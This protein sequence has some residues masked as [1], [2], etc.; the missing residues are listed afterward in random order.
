MIRSIFAIA[1]LV[2]AG[3]AAVQSFPTHVQTQSAAIKQSGGPFSA[4]YAGNYSGSD[5]SAHMNG[6]FQFSG[7]GS[8]SFIH[9]STESGS[10]HGQFINQECRW[11]GT[12]TLT[13]TLHPRNSL[14]MVVGQ[15]P[16]L[17][18]CMDNP[19]VTFGFVTGTGKFANASGSGT[20]V[21]HCNPNNGT[22]TD[23][24]SGTITY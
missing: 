24:W 22:Y 9:Q 12:V 23:H 6:S 5:C 21:F 16:A 7:S 19:K 11:E 3:C 17:L 15:A 14:T 18:P 2:L 4:N 1:A 10:M 8:G 20:I 13:S